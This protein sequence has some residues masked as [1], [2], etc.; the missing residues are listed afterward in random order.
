MDNLLTQSMDLIPIN[1]VMPRNLLKLFT[2]IIDQK[3]HAVTQHAVT[4]IF[5]LFPKEREREREYENILNLRYFLFLLEILITNCH[6]K[7]CHRRIY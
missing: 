1:Y 3:E 6:N 5:L 4:Q 7:N 2:R